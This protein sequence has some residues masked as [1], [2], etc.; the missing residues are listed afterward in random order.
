MDM[1]R[2]VETIVNAVANRRKGYVCAT[3]VHGVMEAQRDPALREIF[4]QALMV[5]PDGM[6]TVWMGRLQGL[7]Q[8]R[9]VFGPDLMLAVTADPALQECSHFLY[10]GAHGVADQL[11]LSL[12]RHFPA[13]RIVGTC[14]PPF[15][16]LNKAEERDLSETIARV[17]PDIFWVGLSTPKQER[18]MAEY[19]PRLDTTLMIGVGAAFDFLAGTKRQ[20]P[21]WMQRHALEWLFRLYSEPRRLW[22][23]YAYIVPGFAFLA[24]SELLRRAVRRNGSA[25]RALSRKYH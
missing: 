7:R 19:L 12:R 4:S 25:R 17:R 15:R 8:M 24:V 2:A 9:R 18:F 5:V 14:T 20:A 13:I 11:E 10:G 3:G 6:P 23:R 1:A 16:P 21:K 22:R